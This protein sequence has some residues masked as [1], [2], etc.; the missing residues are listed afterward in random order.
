MNT[1]KE[2]KG[3]KL[4][5]NPEYICLVT[6]RNTS[7]CPCLICLLKGVCSTSCEDYNLVCKRSKDAMPSV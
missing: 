1:D 5:Y 3:C 4:Y 2:C 7:G 6:D